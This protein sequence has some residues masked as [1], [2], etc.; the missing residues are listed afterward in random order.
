MLPPIRSIR[1]RDGRVVRFNQS[2]ITVAIFKAA[3]SLGGK[4]HAEANRVANEVVRRLFQK[5]RANQIPTVE[6][7]QDLV[8]RTLHA[9]GHDSTA[10]A[11]ALYRHRRNVER[12][13]RQLLGVRDE[14]K[15]SLNSIQVLEKRYLRRNREGK[16]IETPDQ[17]FRRVARHISRAER[18]FDHRPF[19]HRPVQVRS[20]ENAFYQIMASLDFLPNS[21]CL[22]NAGTRL[23]QLAACFILPVP[24]SIPGIFEAV[25]QAAII[26]KTAGGTGFCFSYLRPKGD[27]VQSTSGIASGPLSFMTA[28]DNATYIVKQ[29]GRRRGANMGVL[30]VWHPDILQFIAAKQTPGML[31][32]F[33]VSVA[34]DDT[35]MRSVEKNGNYA[36][37]NPRNHK[38]VQKL[39]ARHIFDRITQS[40]WK[41]AEPG[42]LFMDTIDRH[43]PTPRYPIHATNPCGEV[44]MPDY[45]SC[46]LGS[47]NLARFASFDWSGENWK[48]KIDWKRLRET[49]R[50]AIRFLDNVVELNRYPLP[51]IRRQ[52]LHHR[53]LGLGVMGFAR[54]LAQIGVRYDSREGYAVGGTLM[55]F[56][57][58]EARQMS[59]EL[60]RERGSFPGFRES[61]WAKHYPAMRNATVTSIAPTGSISMIAD[62]TSGIEP[63]FALSYLKTVRAG[64]YHYSEASFEHMLKLRRL[65]N[66]SILQKVAHEG[67]IQKMKGIPFDLRQVFR[68]AYDIPP[69]AHVRMQAVFQ[70]STD[71]A[72]SKTINMPFKATARD[73]AGVY[74]LAW[75]LGCKGITIYRDRSRAEQ[76]LHVGLKTRTPGVAIE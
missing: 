38:A 50:L 42:M 11:Y 60:G 75:K 35:F 12:R 40:A 43:N 14:L 4:D 69:E 5:F 13:M 47:I 21:P 68:V 34:V 6:Q 46:T 57:T 67:S 1:K 22:M 73:V 17:M 2:K 62:T 25:K 66:G 33:N 49:V 74:L 76:V 7:V 59:L 37:V 48:K 53:R 30:H 52:T 71:L 36:L 65:Y 18:K 10:R 24:D 20:M 26:H 45:E 51:P 64:R 29:G 3:R 16:I 56:I 19:G 23:G 54:L 55:R 61:V 70:Q 63:I 41:S 32:N 58:R 27:T 9:T 72:V 28:F 39:K 8:V 15:L 31:E 44:T